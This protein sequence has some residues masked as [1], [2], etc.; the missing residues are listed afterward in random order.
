MRSNMACSRRRFEIECA[1]ADAGR[2]TDENERL[3]ITFHPGCWGFWHSSRRRAPSPRSRR[4]RPLGAFR[5][6]AL[7]RGNWRKRDRGWLLRTSGFFGSRQC[8]VAKHRAPS[9][10]GAQQL[11]KRRTIG[12][13]FVRATGSLRHRARLA[14]CSEHRRLRVAAVCGHRAALRVIRTPLLWRAFRM[15]PSLIRAAV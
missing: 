1:A 11:R 13:A 5:R 8:Q 10:S 6:F 9:N 2:Y 7:G 14:R 4:S 3:L 12:P 15:G